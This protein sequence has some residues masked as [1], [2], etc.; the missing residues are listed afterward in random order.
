MCDTRIPSRGG[1]VTNPSHKPSS[2]SPSTARGPSGDRVVQHYTGS[3]PC[4][5]EG[6]RKSPWVVDTHGQLSRLAFQ[7]C[8]DDEI[9]FRNSNRN[10]PA[11]LASG[12]GHGR[13][14]F[15]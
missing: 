8:S 1:S 14:D 5:I 12:A 7:D 2:S 15:G 4:P 10:V 11:D 13:F 9:P 3:Q 6:I